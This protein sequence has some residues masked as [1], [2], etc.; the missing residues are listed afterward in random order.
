MYGGGIVL[1]TISTRLQAGFGIGQSLWGIRGY[2]HTPPAALFKRVA[3][4]YARS[5]LAVR[6]RFLARSNLY[7]IFGGTGHHPRTGCCLQAHFTKAILI[8]VK[9]AGSGAIAA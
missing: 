2:A 6:P 7:A 1:D 3:S 5:P 8:F 9:S 4:R